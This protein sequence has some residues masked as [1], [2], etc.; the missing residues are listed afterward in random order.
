[1]FDNMAMLGIATL[2]QLVMQKISEK[3]KMSFLIVTKWSSTKWMIKESRVRKDR[4]RERERERERGSSSIISIIRAISFIHAQKIL[5]S[6]DLA[7][8]HSVRSTNPSWWWLQINEDECKKQVSF[9]SITMARAWTS[10]SYL[11][12]HSVRSTNPNWSHLRCQKKLRLFI[13]FKAISSPTQ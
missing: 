7:K 8:I 4:K 1:M 3:V 10:R 6:M 2:L 12:I 13:D 5:Q 11:Q 9:H